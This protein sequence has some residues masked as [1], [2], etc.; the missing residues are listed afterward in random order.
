MSKLMADMEAAY[1]ACREA[2]ADPGGA[3]TGDPAMSNVSFD[4]P[5]G[6]LDPASVA[7]TALPAH[8]T[9]AVEGR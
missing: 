4:D 9:V 3:V 8:G 7:I 5:D 1:R 6:T 2:G